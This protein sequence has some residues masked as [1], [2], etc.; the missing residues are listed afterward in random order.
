MYKFKLFFLSIFLIFISFLYYNSYSYSI[1]KEVIINT[2]NEWIVNIYAWWDIMLSRYVWYLNKTKWYDRIFKDYNPINSFSWWI[3]IF[4]LE[5]PFSKTDKDSSKRTFSFWANIKN[6]ILLKEIIWE[7]KW[8]FSIANNHILNSWK[9]GYELTK[10]ILKEEGFQYIWDKNSLFKSEVVNN[11][12]VCFSSYS[13]DGTD[14]YIKKLSLNNIKTDVK[15][16]NKANCEIK[17]IMPHWGEEY[18]YNPTKEQRKLAYE[19]IDAWID[20]ILWSHSHIPWEIEYYKN[21]LIIYSLGNYIFDQNWWMQWCEK[22]MD[23]SYDKQ[24]KKQTV[25][26]YIGTLLNIKVNIKNKEIKIENIKNHKIDN[27]KIIKIQQ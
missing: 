3:S 11:I 23:C 8:I 16:M 4:N 12:K 9:E 27:G 21:K 26:T 20:I 5:S 24:L 1:K 17:I 22:W 14:S 18:K 6:K 10:N 7:N 19:I 25:P 2:S 15:A 13:Y